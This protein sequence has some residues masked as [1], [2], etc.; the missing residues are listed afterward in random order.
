MSN[1][2]S[3]DGLPEEIQ[4]KIMQVLGRDTL[5]VK[6]VTI[7]EILPDLD[8]P[9]AKKEQISK[10]LEPKNIVR[11]REEETNHARLEALTNKYKNKSN[12]PNPNIEVL[13]N[14]LERQKQERRNSR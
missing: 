2:I 4:I 13:R 5:P 6:K 3:L 7:Q 10:I 8:L 14:E 11:A 1:T 9:Q 12:K